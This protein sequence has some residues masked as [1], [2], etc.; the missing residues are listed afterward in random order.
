M[1]RVKVAEPA[2]GHV[3]EVDADSPLA[4]AWRP[5][6]NEKPTKKSAPSKKK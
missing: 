4:K 2:T 6:E 5:V 3:V 1:T